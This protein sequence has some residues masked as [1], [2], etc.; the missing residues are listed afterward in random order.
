MNRQA[1]QFDLKYV[2]AL[3]REE[4]HPDP[5]RHKMYRLY[6]ADHFIAYRAL[7]ED[8]S[9][10]ERDSTEDWYFEFNR[11]ASDEQLHEEF[12]QFLKRIKSS[13]NY[14]TIRTSTSNRNGLSPGRSGKSLNQ[15]KKRG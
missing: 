6:R 15:S 5:P 1:R 2:K 11:G 10:E 13:M 3:K 8:E 9:W 12:A 4:Q 7:K 14:G